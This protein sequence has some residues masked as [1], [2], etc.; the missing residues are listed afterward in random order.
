M[1]EGSEDLSGRIAALAGAVAGPASADVDRQARFPEE[2]MA[3]LGAAGALGALVPTDLGG[4][5]AT[6]SQIASGTSELARHC[7]STAMVFAM[8]Q[9][10]VACLVRHGASG[11]LREFL[12]RVAAA[13]LLLASATTEASAGGD[14]RRSGCAVEGDE[15]RFRLEKNASVISYGQRAD[16]VLATAR[17]SP[18]SP[19][20]DQVLVLCRR[21]GLTLEPNGTWDTLGFRGTCS[22]GFRLVTE[23]ES[24]CILTD[25]FSDISTQTMLPVS[26][27]LW[28]SVWLGLA[29]AAEDRARRFV[30]GEARK[31]PGTTPRSAL[32]LA[33]LEVQ[34][35][36]MSALVTGAARHFDGV[37]EDRSVLGLTRF[38]VEMNTLKV[39]ASELVVRVV[40]AAMAICGMAGYREDSPFSMGRL[41]RDSMGAVLMIN[42]D[43]VLNNN[44]QLLLALRNEL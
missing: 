8:H 5:G 9:I 23:D 17:R 43:R 39:G 28:A 21:P 29:Q 41:L 18:D 35:G 24:G 34:L 11:F 19:P 16:A 20:G 25:A 42:N 36:Q 38:T 1:A 22:L 15:G 31:A 7:A 44:A 3:A 40:E 10:Q 33:E 6:L 37:A 4:A 27:I 32:R 2:A 12:G 13:P 14:L 26:H 30:Q